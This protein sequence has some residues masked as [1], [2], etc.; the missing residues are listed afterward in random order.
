MNDIFKFRDYLIDV[1]QRFSQGFCL[2]R[3][4]DIKQLVQEAYHNQ[5]RYWPEPLIQLSVNYEKGASLNQLI[6]EGVLHS[7]CRQIF[8]IA[9][10]PISLYR[11]Q[12]RAVLCAS[13]QKNYVVTTGTGSGKSLTFFIP[14]VSAILNEK[15]AS[16]STVSRVRAIIIYP[17]NALANSQEKEIQKFLQNWSDCPIRV[18]RYTGQESTEEKRQLANNPPD[19]LLTNYMMLEWMLTRRKLE[20]D[21]L[22]IDSCIDLRFLVLD[23]LH[24]YRGRQGADVAM[25]VRRLRATTKSH[26]ML[27]IGTSATM[28]SS[29]NTLERAESVKRVSGLLFGISPD[30]IQVIEESLLRVTDSTVNKGDL[31]R[32][33]RAY[34][35]NP[36]LATTLAPAQL[37]RH[38]LAIWCELNL[39]VSV[40]PGQPMRRAIPKSLTN[41][42]AVLRNDLESDGAPAVNIS[43]DE[44]KLSLKTFL[45]SAH[46]TKDNGRSPFAFKLHQFISGPGRVMLTLEELG[47]RY[48][49]LEPQSFAPLNRPLFTAY[50][51]RSCGHEY[52]PVYYDTAN[53]KFSPRPIESITG[54]EDDDVDSVGFL[55]PA[56]DINERV[57]KGGGSTA[58]L[59]DLWLEEKNEVLRVKSNYKKL[60]PKEY[61]VDAFG[62][63]SSI[64][65][66]LYYFTP[67]RFKF[68]PQCGH[69]HTSKERD[70][71]RLASLSGESRASATTIITQSALLHLF[72]KLEATKND[73]LRNQLKSYCKLLGFTDNRQDAALQAGHFNDFHRLIVL[74]SAIYKAILQDK[75]N[76]GLTI[77]ELVDK[78]FCYL[79]FGVNSERM[80]SHYLKD[81]NLETKAL[82]KALQYIRFYLGYQLYRDLRESWRY[83]IPSLEKLHLLKIEFEGMIDLMEDETLAKRSSLYA[84]LNKDEKGEVLNLIFNTMRQKRCILA[85]E[86]DPHRQEYLRPYAAQIQD[87]WVLNHY[88]ADCSAVLLFDRKRQDKNDANLLISPRSGLVQAIKRLC[89]KFYSEP[90]SGNDVVILIHRIVERA[91]DFGIT[92]EQGKSNR[93]QLLSS[94][95]RWKNV[96]DDKKQ[97]KG[98]HYNLFFKTLFE[99]VSE[100]LT[101]QEHRLFDLIAAEHTAQV[102]HDEREQLEIRF[103]AEDTD[104]P[105]SLLPLPL[106]FC[107]PTM[108]LGVDI[109]SLNFVYMRNVPPTSANYAQRS[110]RAG[111]SGEPAIA[112]SYCHALSPHDLWFFNHP[113][114]MVSGVVKPPVLDLK[115]K[116]LIDSH[117][118]ATLLG[119]MRSPL[120][121][122]ISNILDLDNAET[123]TNGEFDYPVKQKYSQSFQCDKIKRI[124]LEELM[125][126]F[127]FNAG[128]AKSDWED[129]LGESIE[130]YC[131]KSLDASGQIFNQSFDLWRELYRTTIMQ[132]DETYKLLSS[133]SFVRESEERRMVEARHRQACVHFNQLVSSSHHGES[134]NGGGDF[135]T[136]RYL[137]SQGFI[138]GYNFPR[139]PLI[140]WIEQESVELFQGRPSGR[141]LSRPRFLALQE[142]GPNSLIYHSGRIYQVDSLKIGP[143]KNKGA[144]H[145]PT[146]C[147]QFCEFCGHSVV[148]DDTQPQYDVCENCQE[149]LSPAIQSLYQIES[150]VTKRKDFISA[151]DEE[152]RKQG[153]EVQTYYRFAQIRGRLQKRQGEVHGADGKVLVNL[154]YGPS[155]TIWKINK[156][157]SRRINKDLLGFNIDPMTGKWCSEPK[158]EKGAKS[159]PSRR[160]QR[161]V[162]YVKDIRNIIIIKIPEHYANNDKFMP[163][164]QAALSV[165]IARHFEV[166][167]SEIGVD[168]LYKQ[169][170]GDGLLIYEAAEGGAGILRCLVDEPDRLSKVAKEV[171]AALHFDPYT[172]AQLETECNQACYRCLLQ[173]SNQIDH[174]KIDRT[175]PQLHEWLMELR[176]STIHLQ[177]PI[178][179]PT[180]LDE[181]PASRWKKELETL[182]LQEPSEYDKEIASLELHID[183]FYADRC[184]CVFLGEL[185]TKAAVLQDLN[186]RSIAFAK[187]GSNWDEQFQKLTDYLS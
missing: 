149:P 77:S 44:L 97:T 111:R 121:G 29:D 125:S 65:H 110:G 39:G 98:V 136:Y 181:S 128:V 114:Q 127:E 17:M 108:E 129:C 89:A 3:S 45:I 75:S 24:T 84:R 157:L 27:C 56:G 25:L 166:E 10:N 60:I 122:E 115:N 40:Q 160:T 41:L 187:D 120:P 11:H 100:Q 14:I 95:L 172:G 7:D 67:G 179:V 109:S 123:S 104:S 154:S 164:V 47:K 142:F 116:D 182:N 35:N 4:K 51:C 34:F 72:G 140:A 186:W 9:G 79:G 5:A 88:D 117:I 185:P 156:G 86:L 58:G 101:G 113:E 145:L 74:R 137:A 184:L 169:Q 30:L 28:S 178:N 87:V 52:L 102:G 138:P 33:L 21:A 144:S 183:A 146:Q 59:P 170:D 94:C 174:E 158:D 173:Y 42:V 112:L 159:E 12:E 153:F 55:T 107:S 48:I 132:R 49:T 61:R 36:T 105:Q 46:Q 76:A 8:Q 139:L 143:L 133:P 151:Q 22:L 152:R 64:R 20:N 167:P 168:S 26:Q 176:N 130:L 50:F 85:D 6:N 163:T 1:H 171:L 99:V 177:T 135:Y 62:N 31:P 71:N 93:Y 78:V 119:A 90:P 134:L 106:M 63:I 126:L 161:I 15:A 131:K 66:P 81:K 19:I 148:L 32:L 141:M 91:C 180:P 23:E 53:R 96:S 155:A 92:L 124:A 37:R 43:D 118:R 82:Q 162:P 68:C 147:L 73:I 38:P 69:Y 70:Y 150:V 16:N 54:L 18:G 83:N 165:G 80:K 103:R 2:I 57:F 175:L 13:E